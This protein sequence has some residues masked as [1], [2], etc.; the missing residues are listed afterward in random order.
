MA[1]DKNKNAPLYMCGSCN[2]RRATFDPKAKE[3]VCSCGHSQNIPPCFGRY[4]EPGM[5]WT[6]SEGDCSQSCPARLECFKKRH[7]G[8]T[9]G[10]E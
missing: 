2:K 5:P 1:I 7:N 9:K 10:K 6:D 4:M 3:F 8:A